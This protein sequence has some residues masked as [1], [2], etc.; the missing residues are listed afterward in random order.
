MEEANIQCNRRGTTSAET[1]ALGLLPC[2]D[3]AKITPEG[4]NMAQRTFCVAMRTGGQLEHT[5]G[6][7]GVCGTWLVSHLS[8]GSH[9]CELRAN[10][11]WPA[12]VRLCVCVRG[13]QEC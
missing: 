5:A 13:R 4:T 12:A 8:R 10:T 3:G 11:Q 7:R 1:L 6:C 9:A 2:S